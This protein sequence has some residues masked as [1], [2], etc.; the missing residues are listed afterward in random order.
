MATLEGPDVQASDGE[1]DDGEDIPPLG[2]NDNI[3]AIVES[4]WVQMAFDIMYV[5]PNPK[6]HRK[7]AYVLLDQEARTS[8]T[9][10]T[11]Q[12]S[13]LTGIFR[14]VLYRELTSSQWETV[15]FDSFFPLPNS[16]A[17]KRQG[18]R[19]ASYY[20]KWHHLMARLRRRDIVVVRNELRRQ[21]RT[22]LWVPHPD[23]D[24]M[25][26]TRSSMRG[27]TRLPASST[28]PCPLIAINRQALQ[29]TRITLN[30][31]IDDVEQGEMDE[32]DF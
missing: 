22:L 10:A 9:P 11:F 26:R 21:F 27:F 13:D 7:P 29:G 5:S 20:K 23:T 14:S 30:P 12:R 17:L 4:I 1:S 18:F 25:W 8:T 16:A 24:R 19:A 3:D 28:G 2:E 6:D 31:P 32:E 15:V